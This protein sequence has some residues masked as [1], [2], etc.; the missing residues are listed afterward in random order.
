MKR[1]D[2][3]KT[4][5]IAL[6]AIAM[7]GISYGELYTW[8]GSVDADWANA[9]NWDGAL[10]STSLATAGTTWNANELD[11]ITFNG[12]IMPSSNIPTFAGWEGCDNMIFNDGGT[13]TVDLS[14][15]GDA[16][17]VG[18]PRT[19]LTVGDG[20]GSAASVTVNVTGGILNRH[21]NGASPLDPVNYLV[22]SDGVL[23]IGSL[24]LYGD[25]GKN[26]TFEM[27]G[28][29]LVADDVVA[30]NW[31]LDHADNGNSYKTTSYFSFNAEGSS[32][33][34]DFGGIYTD[35]DAVTTD[36]YDHLREGSGITLEYADNLDGSFTVTAIPE[37][38]TLGLVAAFGGGILFIRRFMQI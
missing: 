9:G 22:N 29:S 2:R 12:S 5:L 33:T 18:K 16:G 19:F 17:V 30:L 31:N 4:G 8:N 11:T 23:N 34:A 13:F 32:F 37:P 26:V 20:V 10:V 3:T 7:S 24:A 15:T 28:G 21:T 1:I 35:I 36:T 14:T 38:A 27:N 6:V 25:M